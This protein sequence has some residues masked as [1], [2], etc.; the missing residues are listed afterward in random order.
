MKYQADFRF[1]SNSISKE[2]SKPLDS[3]SKPQLS[4]FHLIQILYAHQHVVRSHCFCYEDI[5][6]L[7]IQ[8]PGELFEVVLRKNADLV[9]Y[10]CSPQLV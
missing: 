7:K 3:N 2:Q 1:E 5:R 4:T 6:S 8:G 9:A 10:M